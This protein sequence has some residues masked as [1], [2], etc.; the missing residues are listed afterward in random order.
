MRSVAIPTIQQEGYRA[1]VRRRKRIAERRGKIKQKINGFLLASGI[2]EPQSIRKW[3]LVASADL[4]AL[5]M[6]P[7]HRMSLASM[8]REYLFLLSEDKTLRIEIRAATKRTRAERF[9]QPTSIVSVGE[10]RIE[11]LG[12]AVLSR[13]AQPPR[14]SDIISRSRSH[15]QPKW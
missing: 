6:P 2:A 12:L 15:S 9:A 1:L 7:E 5:D 14:G 3:S 13:T 4:S 8:V 10:T 11:L